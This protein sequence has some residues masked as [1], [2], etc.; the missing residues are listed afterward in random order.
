MFFMSSFVL[1]LAQFLNQLLLTINFFI[2]LFN[3][4]FFF[5]YPNC[6]SF[7]LLL[8][9]FSFEFWAF[10]SLFWVFVHVLIEQSSFELSS[11]KIDFGSA[12]ILGK[13]KKNF[14]EVF[15]LFTQKKKK[16]SL[17]IK[18]C[19]LLCSR[20]KKM[21]N[22]SIFKQEHNFG[23]YYILVESDSYNYYQI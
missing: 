10:V 7:L 16:K 13:R 14:V 12:I 22:T 8:L 2:I 5:Y 6:T 15:N 20:F 23:K 11:F 17:S 1:G 18:V 4:S 19:S 9:F 3:A 21:T